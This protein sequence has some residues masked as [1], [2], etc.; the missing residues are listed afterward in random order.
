MTTVRRATTAA[1]IISASDPLR[2]LLR[3]LEEP[4]QHFGAILLRHHLG[5]LAMDCQP[6]KLGSPVR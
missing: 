1:G 3:A 5:E 6:V 2:V 4:G